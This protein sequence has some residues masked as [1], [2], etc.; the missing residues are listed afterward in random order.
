MRALSLITWQYCSSFHHVCFTPSPP[1]LCVE[2]FRSLLECGQ[3]RPFCPI[4]WQNQGKK[5][6][7]SNFTLVNR[8]NSDTRNRDPFLCRSLNWLTTG[9]SSVP[10][11]LL[12]FLFFFDFQLAAAQSS[13][14]TVSLLF[15]PCAKA[16][17]SGLK[18]A[19]GT[20]NKK[21]RKRLEDD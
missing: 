17:A 15:F 21:R 9:G 6:S 3:Q 5:N 1:S 13:G 12:H 19:R 16:S 11:L 4:M 14:T 7:C 20:E 18:T 10:S 8:L 2:A